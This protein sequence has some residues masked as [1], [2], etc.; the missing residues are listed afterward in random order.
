M[1]TGSFEMNASGLKSTVFLFFWKL[2]QFEF[3]ISSEKKETIYATMIE[4]LKEKIGTRYEYIKPKYNTNKIRYYN[5]Q[6]S[7]KCLKIS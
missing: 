7:D 6:E 1:W 3:Q 2:N 4:K 5:I